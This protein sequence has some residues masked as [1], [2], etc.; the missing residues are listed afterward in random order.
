MVEL[1]IFLGESL[2]WIYR[3]L[4]R[5]FQQRKQLFSI[6]RKHFIRDMIQM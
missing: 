4:R 2:T 6:F 3:S 5:A 1:R